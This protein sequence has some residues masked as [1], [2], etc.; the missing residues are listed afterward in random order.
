MPK[1]LISD[2]LSP[3]AM[4]VFEERGLTAEMKTGLSKEELLAIIGEYDGLAIRSATK[5]T[6]ELIKAAKNLKVVG[7]ADDGA[8][9][10][11]PRGKRLDSVR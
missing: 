6:P 8:G 5:V 2:P 9:T 1:V 3:A 4:A 10:R 11:Y 7:R